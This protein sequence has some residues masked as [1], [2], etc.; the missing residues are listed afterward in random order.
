MEFGS[1]DALV[2]HAKERRSPKKLAVA[3]AADIHV[4]EAVSR[5]WEEKIIIP[6]LIG[7]KSEIVR[8]L[9]DLC[10]TLPSDAIIHEPDPVCAAR[11]AVKLVREGEAEILMKGLINTSELLREVLNH[12]TGLKHETIISHISIN[13]IPTYHKLLI[14]T[15]AGIVIRPSLEEKAAIVRNAVNALRAVGYEKPKVAVLAALEKVNVKMPETVD[16]AALKEMNRKGEL[17][18]CCVEGPISL[19]LAIDAESAKIK[20]FDSPV[21]GDPDIVVVPDIACGNILNKSLRLL[22]GS[23][24]VGM[25]MGAQVPIALTSRGASAESKYLS[26]AAASVMA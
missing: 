25:V 22:A 5:A 16:A 1:I 12:E 13:Q 8:R 7:D 11:K 9:N 21:V 15:D 6:Y 10:V 17:K 20:G 19:D 23:K 3:A 26:I 14:V 24:Q 2:Q 4:L 18:G